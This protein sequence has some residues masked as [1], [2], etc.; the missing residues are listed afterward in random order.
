LRP[1]TLTA[2]GLLVVVLGGAS[3]AMAAGALI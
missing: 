2:A 1:A 3:A